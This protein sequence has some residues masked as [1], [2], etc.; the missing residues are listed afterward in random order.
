M[1][2]RLCIAPALLA[3]VGTNQWLRNLDS[4]ASRIITLIQDWHITYEWRCCDWLSADHSGL[5]AAAIRETRPHSLTVELII[6]HV[7]SASFFHYW[8]DIFFRRIFILRPAF[9]R[10]RRSLAML[11][12]CRTVRGLNNNNNDNNNHSITIAPASSPLFW[13]EQP[14]VPR[15][16]S[17]FDLGQT[18]SPGIQLTQGCRLHLQ[19]Q[20]KWIA[21]P[22]IHPLF[23]GNKWKTWQ[24]TSACSEFC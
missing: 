16:S 7:L 21:I 3:V 13:A 11:R 20:P 2:S 4:E 22:L 10:V 23:L 5:R 14:G 6:Q 19:T 8:S 24:F 12:D 1:F 15:V 9:L 17:M 18:S